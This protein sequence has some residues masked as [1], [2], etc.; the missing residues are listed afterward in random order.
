MTNT[1]TSSP[2]DFPFGD[3]QSVYCVQHVLVHK[4]SVSGN[5]SE[6]HLLAFVSAETVINPKPKHITFHVPVGRVDTL[7]S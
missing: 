6:V 7:E 5:N 4:T 3:I 2:N 1:F